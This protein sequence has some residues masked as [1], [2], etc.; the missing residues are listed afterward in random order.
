MEE[1]E[2]FL[3]IYVAALTQFHNIQ[4]PSWDLFLLGH[5]DDD[6]VLEGENAVIS[7]SRY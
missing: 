1:S 4:M 5:T 3:N 2:F 7:V 6:D